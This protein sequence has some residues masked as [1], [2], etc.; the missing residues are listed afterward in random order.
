L[1][2]RAD[3]IIVNSQSAADDA[4]SG[5]PH[6]ADKLHVLGF[7]PVL[8]EAVLK[9]DP[10]EVRRK[11]NLPGR[12][13]LVCN[14]FWQ[15]KNHELVLRALGQLKRYGKVPPVVAF[16]GL[17][18][19]YRNPDS[20]SQLLKSMHEEGLNDYCRF[21]GV[22]PREEQLALLRASE[23]VIQPSRFE[24]RGAI[25]E[26]ATLLGTQ[27]LCSDLPVHRELNIPGALFFSV[28]G[29]EELAELMARD[30]QRSSK[31]TEDIVAESRRL[32]ANYG[33]QLM[34]VFSR[35]KAKYR[36]R[37]PSK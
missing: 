35:V 6:I 17:P 10:D 2:E 27:L 1:T 21:L 15:H 3:G 11:Y 18:H 33:A 36:Q 20:F 31:S 32:A 13:L 16:T 4:L 22:L 12:F 9:R 28:D 34:D 30:Y 24:G 19:D 26:E 7:P 8:H 37:M 5:H 14:Q 23:A 25:G 29:V